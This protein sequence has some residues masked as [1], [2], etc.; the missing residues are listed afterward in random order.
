MEC[1]AVRIIG[2]LSAKQ[3]EIKPKLQ[4]NPFVLCDEKTDR[5]SVKVRAE[6]TDGCLK[7]SG[8]DSSQTPSEFSGEA[9][10][11]S[12][13]TFDE[14]NTERL[15]ACLPKGC[16]I[17]DRML[18]NFSGADGLKRLRA[19]CEKNEIEYDFSNRL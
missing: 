13:Y 7:I 12:F 16:C 8:H 19:F 4:V 1:S 3:N 11:E 14:K 10:Y 18:K 5:V 15:I 17:R 6:I 2:N 9:E